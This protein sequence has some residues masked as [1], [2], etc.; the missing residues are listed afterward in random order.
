MPTLPSAPTLSDFQR[1]ATE[2]EAER[3]FSEQDILQKCLLLGEEVGE[4]FKAVRKETKMTVDENANVSPSAE[5]L[6]DV[7]ILLLCIAN[8]SQVSLEEAFRAKEGAN[9]KRTWR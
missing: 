2:L 9:K 4:L 1:Y 5:E 8:R 6:A 3:G 7:F